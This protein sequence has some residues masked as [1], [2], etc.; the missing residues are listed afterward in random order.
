MNNQFSEEKTIWFTSDTHFNHTNIINYCN[1]PFVF[2]GTP[3]VQSMNQAL[4]EHWNANVSSSDVIYHLGD[5]SFGTKKQASDIL[6]M[7][8]GYKVL[9]KGNHDRSLS[10]M[11]EI[12]FDLVF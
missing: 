11:K 7:L 6:H 2:D 3:N 4:I 1:R 10:S 9:I 12:G 8:N 5:F